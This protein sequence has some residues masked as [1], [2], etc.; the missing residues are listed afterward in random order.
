MT[1]SRTL[2]GAFL[3]VLLLPASIF[4]QATTGQMT[5]T[6]QQSGAPLPGVTVT[7]SSPQLQGTRTTTTNENGTYNFPAL[8]PGDYTVVFSLEGMQTVTRKT[9]VGLVTTS[10]VDADLKMASVA[11]AIT[12]TASA[13]TV[14]ETT[15]VETN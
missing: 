9:N 10:R 8:P 13:P 14:L 4:A 6:V 5:G 2:I 15:Q 3:V 11:E 1:R 7:I 12:V